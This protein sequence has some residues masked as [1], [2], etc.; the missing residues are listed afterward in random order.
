[1]GDQYC[2]LG[3]YKESCAKT[4]VE[5]TDLPENSL[6]NEAVKVLREQ[7]FKVSMNFDNFKSLSCLSF[8]H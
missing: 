4:E 1:M 6:L 3:P 8:C 7:G 2:L 5:E